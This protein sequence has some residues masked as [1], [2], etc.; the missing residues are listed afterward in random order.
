M[1]RCASRW[2]HL[3]QS[4]LSYLFCVKFVKPRLFVLKKDAETDTDDLEAFAQPAPTRRAPR[5]SRAFDEERPHRIAASP[6]SSRRQSGYLSPRGQVDVA[7]SNSG[8]SESGRAEAEYDNYLSRQSEVA[9]SSLKP[10]GPRPTSSRY[11]SP[12]AEGAEV[13]ALGSPR[14]SSSFRRRVTETH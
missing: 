11:R 4:A 6:S 2:W 12:L 3:D 1:Q 7:R 14:S 8:E 9:A 13:P 5:S 10:S